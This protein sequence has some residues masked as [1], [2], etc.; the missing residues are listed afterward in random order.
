MALV[1]TLASKMPVVKLGRMAGQFAK[2]RSA[3]LEDVD[4]V[5]LPS[6]RGDLINDIPFEAGGREP[7][8]QRLDKA[9]NQSAGYR[10]LLRSTPHSGIAHTTNVN[11]KAEPRG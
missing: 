9:Y 11:S 2:P 4:G 6:Y 3:D 5:S 8:P 1:L 10:H 7:D